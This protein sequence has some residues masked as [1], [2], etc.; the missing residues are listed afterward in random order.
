M[1]KNI[2]M[3]EIES[4]IN[5]LL[6][7]ILLKLEIEVIYLENIE[8]YLNY[9]LNKNLEYNLISRKLTIEEIIYDHVFDCLVCWEY[10]KK[11]SSITDLGSG[12][13]LPGILLSI[14]FPDK[15][16]FLI[17]KSPVKA[18]FLQDAV[19]NINLKNVTIIKGLVNEQ[20]IETEV[21]T[22]RAFKDILTILT[23]T[24]DF[25]KRGGVYLLYKARRELI[26]EELS[27]AKKHFKIKEEIYKIGK[28]EEKER[29]IVFI[30]KV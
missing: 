17:E 29:H 4:K 16:I 20:K 5:D 7:G 18:N 10:F 19:N 14:I 24:D 15:K 9:L 22:C 6:R 28:I 21:I 25:Y 3:K 13:G 12:G 8:K 1:K 30:K 23:V 2:I 11:Y 27:R 26:E